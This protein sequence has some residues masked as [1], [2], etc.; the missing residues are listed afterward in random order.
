MIHQTNQY[1]LWKNSAWMLDQWHEAN[2]EQKLEYLCMLA[3][4]APSTHNTQPWRF[5]CNT[6]T[7]TIEMY[8]DRAFI[9]PASDVVGR[10]SVISAGCAIGNILSVA[11][12]YGFSLS[13]DMYDAHVLPGSTG[14]LAHII[15]LHI[16]HIPPVTSNSNLVHAIF[17]RKIQRAE[18]D[19]TRALP[20]DV[21]ISQ[22]ICEEGITLHFISDRLRRKSV[23]E[24]QGQADGFVMNSKKFSR[25][26]GEWMLP[27]DTSSSVG[28]PGNGFGLQDEQAARIHRG[29]LGEE[30]LH[31]EDGLKFAIAGKDGIEKAPLVGFLTATKDDIHHWINTGI[32]LEKIFLRM[33]SSNISVAI[34]AGIVEVGLV[35]KM[36]AM[37]LGTT[38]RI[39]ALFRAGYL[40]NPEDNK[41]PHTPRLSMNEVLLD[42]PIS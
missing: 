8:L 16:H 25:E 10:Q 4:L 42:H 21:S 19:P 2:D 32:T 23:A 17:N 36:F 15:S 35:N 38:K 7:Q 22:D 33:T 5:F 30:A 37:T 20:D 24:F 27:N 13:M 6:S 11:D 28:M 29:M 39:T 34:N 40:K 3:H 26:L 12:F 9:L 14:E 31:P 18:M 41:R 1:E